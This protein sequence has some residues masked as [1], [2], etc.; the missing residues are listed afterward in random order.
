METAVLVVWWI[1]LVGALVLTLI[2]LTQVLLVIGTLRGILRLAE[3][4]RDAAGGIAANV[5]AVDGLAGLG[6]LVRPM[7]AAL[8]AV[9]RPVA[10]I[11]RRVEAAAGEGA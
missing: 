11:A 8:A 2:I 1:G 9:A 6:G 10:A 5:A 4:T 7:P 3:L